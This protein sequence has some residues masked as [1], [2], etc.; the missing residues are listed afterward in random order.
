MSDSGLPDNSEVSRRTAVAWLECQRTGLDFYDWVENQT[1][2]W[3]HSGDFTAMRDFVLELC[4]TADDQQTIERIG[5]G[6]LYDM[7]RIWPD[8]TL[9]LVE[10]EAD[11]NP[12]LLQALSIVMTSKAS[13]RQRIDAILGRHGQQ[14]S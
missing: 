12:S 5:V 2:E 11:T 6:P 14:P 10:A 7:V 3:M 8:L 1:L 13:V 9:K 4:E